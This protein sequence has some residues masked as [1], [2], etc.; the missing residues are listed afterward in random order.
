[1]FSLRLEIE[2]LLKGP[3]LYRCFKAHRQSPFSS[4]SSK[5]CRKSGPFPPP[6]LLGLNGRMDLSDARSSRHLTWRSGWRTPLNRTSPDNPHCLA[7]VL[8]PLPRRTERVRLPASFPVRAAFPVTQSGRHP[9]RYF[10][11]LLGLHSRYGPLACSAAQ[12][13]LRH[14]A[15]ARSLASCLS[16]TRS[17]R[18]LPRWNLPPLATRAYGAHVESRRGAVAGGHEAIAPF[19]LPAHRTGR[20]DFPH[21]ALRPASSQGPR[22]L[23]HGLPGTQTDDPELAEDDIS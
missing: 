11:G 5:A 2:L 12:G 21:P 8:C 18:L 23:S 17:N 3:D 6:Q 10:R 7:S 14:R 16:A 13:G 20:A 1:L 19:P 15:S 9:H 22:L 4:P